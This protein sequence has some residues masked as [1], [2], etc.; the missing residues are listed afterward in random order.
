MLK[1]V[2]SVVVL[3]ALTGCATTGTQGPSEPADARAQRGG[4]CAQALY[5]E[6]KGAGKMTPR[7]TRVF[8]LA[9]N[10]ALADKPVGAKAADEVIRLYK[11]GTLN[12]SQMRIDCIKAY[13]PMLK[14]FQQ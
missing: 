12:L 4:A 14:E 2:L 6:A 1:V 9:Q 8:T 7:A 10:D 3:A 11:E 13:A 5:L